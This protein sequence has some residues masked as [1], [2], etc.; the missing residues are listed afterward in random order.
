MFCLLYAYLYCAKPSEPISMKFGGRMLYGP[1]KKLVN[2]AESRAD[3]LL[4]LIG[5]KALVNFLRSPGFNLNHRHTCFS[6]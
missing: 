5:R 4:N 3:E 2:F 6:K 1:R